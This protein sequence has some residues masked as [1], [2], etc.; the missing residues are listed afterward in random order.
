MLF[1]INRLTLSL[2]VGVE[3]TLYLY[4]LNPTVSL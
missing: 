2:R 3:K 1:M 4:T